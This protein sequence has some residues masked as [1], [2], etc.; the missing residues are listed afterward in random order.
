MIKTTYQIEAIAALFL[1]ISVAGCVPAATSD[2]GKTSFRANGEITCLPTTEHPV[3]KS[4]FANQPSGSLKNGLIS[5]GTTT[6]DGRLVTYTCY[7]GNADRQQ[8]RPCS[9]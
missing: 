7:A 1:M 9:W 6:L 8:S 2:M 4:S 5:S 3:C